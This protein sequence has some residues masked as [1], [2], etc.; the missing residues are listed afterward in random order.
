MIAELLAR[1]M[2]SS[3]KGKLI[4]Q[5]AQEKYDTFFD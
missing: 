4:T 3:T 5:L 1:H 2:P